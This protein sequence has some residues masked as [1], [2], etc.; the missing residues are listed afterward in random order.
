[1]GQ[2]DD[3]EED[4]G[5]EE[6]DD[7]Q[8]AAGSDNQDEQKKAHPDARRQNQRK[9][10]KERLDKLL[11]SRWCGGRGGTDGAQGTHQGWDN[12]GGTDPDT[13]NDFYPK[14]FQRDREDK[15][16]ARL[17]EEM[18]RIPVTGQEAWLDCLVSEIERLCD[19]DS[20]ITNVL[21]TNEMQDLSM[22]N[23]KGTDLKPINDFYLNA[24]VVCKMLEFKANKRYY[25]SLQTESQ[26]RQEH[27][28]KQN[29]VLHEYGCELEDE[30][31]KIMKQIHN[32]RSRK[33]NMLTQLAG[34]LDKG[35][36]S[37]LQASLAAKARD[38]QL[39]QLANGGR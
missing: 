20:I 1:M 36:F 24:D 16:I 31:T 7:D 25:T 12:F 15:D 37:H 34:L 6:P 18:E 35:A 2:V 19:D 28:K 9:R 22:K 10:A 11:F 27:F 3:K 23:Q 30:F 26:Q 33:Q 29:D 5:Q 8:S 32:Y 14:E 39:P 21:R 38:E 4:Q 13:S 17:R